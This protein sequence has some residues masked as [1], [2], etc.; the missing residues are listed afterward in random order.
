MRSICITVLLLTTLSPILV[1]PAV[2]DSFVPDDTIYGHV[3]NATTGDPLSPAFVRCEGKTATT[4]AEGRYAIEGNFA[5]S[6]S[7]IVTCYASGYPSFSKTVATDSDGKAEADFYLGSGEPATPVQDKVTTWSKT[8]GGSDD[9]LIFSVQQTRDD[10]YIIAGS[11]RSYGAGDEDLWL[12][13]TDPE[14]DIEWDRTFGDK[15]F[16]RGVSV[17]Q[18][19]DGAYIVVGGGSEGGWLLQIDSKGSKEWEKYFQSAGGNSIQQTRD[20]GYIIVGGKSINDVRYSDDIW[21]VKTDSYGNKEWEQNFGGPEFEIGYSV[22]QTRDGGYI[23]TGIKALYGGGNERF[24][25][26]K[27]DSYGNKEW[28]QTFL[29]LGPGW[30]GNCVRQTSDGGYIITGSGDPYGAGHMDVWLIKTDSLGNKE[31]DRTFG[32]TESDWGSSVKITYDGGFIIAG[33]TF[34]YGRGKSDIWLIKTDSEG[35]EEWNRTFGGENKDMC[36]WDM[37]SESVVQQAG[38]GGYII[39]GTTESSRGD[40]DIWLIKTD[41]EGYCEQVEEMEK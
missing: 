9:D 18:I 35:H 3:Y 36:P 5:P 22:Q 1:M 17:Q 24:W 15:G 41:S 33:G 31:W 37:P 30:G 6:T 16:D 39:V 20:G 26:I 29:I 11:T 10:G 27:T 19:G 32:G 13:K 12:I 2:G 34:S 23:I 38:D 25:L 40:N 4:D 14:G 28:D 21:L 7:Y 8:F